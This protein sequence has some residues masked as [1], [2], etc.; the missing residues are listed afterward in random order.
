MSHDPVNTEVLPLED[1]QSLRQATAV[2]RRGGLVAMPTDTVYGVAALVFES[3][4]IER[5]YEVKIRTRALPIP[6]LIAS[7]ENLRLVTNHIPQYGRLLASRYW[8]GPL[9]MVFEGS[10]QLPK[11]ISETGT[12]GIRMPDHRFVLSLI[13]MVGPLGMT[14]ANLS[15]EGNAQSAAEVL[16]ALG[17]KID[18]LIDGG[19]TGGSVA[20]TVIDCTGDRPKILR[21]GPISIEEILSVLDV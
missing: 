11:E 10:F 17:G 18:L 8:P 4:S 2:L 1:P 6:V 9:T 16:D 5:L 20:S 21:K 15:G 12:V 3:R 13:E 14:S 19:S 7:P